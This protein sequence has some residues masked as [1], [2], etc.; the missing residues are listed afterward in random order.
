MDCVDPRNTCVRGTLESLDGV[1]GYSNPCG[2][3]SGLSMSQSCVPIDWAQTVGLARGES[4]KWKWHYRRNP[5]AYSEGSIG[6]QVRL[7]FG[8]M[9]VL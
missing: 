1:E 7:A 4:F 8:K 6:M 3:L 9:C 5:P 2:L